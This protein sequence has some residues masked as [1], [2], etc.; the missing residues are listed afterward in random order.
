M[1][2]NNLNEQLE[3]LSKSNGFESFHYASSAFINR[4]VINQSTIF[5]FDDLL[6]NNM[7]SIN[8]CI[9]TI[10]DIGFIDLQ[11]F[12]SSM[13]NRYAS[14]TNN[15]YSNVSN[16]ANN[17]NDN[18][19]NNNNNNYKSNN[20]ISNLSNFN[21]YKPNTCINTATNA[22]ITNGFAVDDDNI[23][24]ITEDD[25]FD[26]LDLLALDIPDSILERI[27]E[28][29]ALAAAAAASDIMNSNKQQQQQQQQHH[30]H[31]QQ[32]QQSGQQ[33]QQ[34]VVNFSNNA[35]VRATSFQSAGNMMM[36]MKHS[37][38][39]F[40]IISTTADGT[41]IG[42]SSSSS[43]TYING[44]LS[45]SQPLLQSYPQQQQQQQQQPQLVSSM[46]ASNSFT[47]IAGQIAKD[48]ERRRDR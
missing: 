38:N 48:L 31:H 32:Q 36:T 34:N 27:D 46:D 22:T 24:V 29:E 33:Q 35:N 5:N 26:T 43:S 28:E 8:S 3:W 19:N 39:D 16:N 4:P 11:S 18:N 10:S 40:G 25:P 17:N 7:N 44:K 41:A 23:V 37:G 13:N 21:T 12:R 30:H 9:Q 47:P 42:N 20:N 1:I 45:T 15:L 6:H 2:N 14:S